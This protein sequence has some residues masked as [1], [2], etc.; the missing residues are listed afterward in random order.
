MKIDLA[1]RSDFAEDLAPHA[2]GECDT[3]SQQL[4]D[5]VSHAGGNDIQL[6]EILRF[7]SRRS[8]ALLIVFM[9]FPLCLPVG[10]PV[11]STTLG[12]TLGFVG[13]LL[14]FGG[15]LR[16]PQRLAA[17]TIQHKR[18]I[19]VIE[20]LVRVACRLERF[21]HPRLHFFAANRH[22]LRIHGLFIMC[23]G[24][25]AAIPLPLP[26]NNMVAA[27]PLVLL[28]LALLQKDGLFVTISYVAAIPCFLYYGA[29]IYFGYAGFKQLIALVNHGAV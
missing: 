28:G 27:F 11:L 26:F 8:H 2:V 10:I 19:Q 14:C 12:L 24:F 9:S 16:I 15:E 29:L 25:L 17:K 20:K 22:A 4:R 18:L 5:L 1:S 6:G 3:L 21:L 23:M 7:L 13:L